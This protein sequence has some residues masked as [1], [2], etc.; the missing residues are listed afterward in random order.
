MS[1]PLTTPPQTEPSRGPWLGLGIGALLVAGII[2]FLIYSSRSSDT[3][4][5]RRA[6]V[7]QATPADPYAAQLSLTDI[8]MFEA[9]NF[10][11][12][13]SIYVEGKITNNGDKTVVGATI[14]GTFKNALDQVVQ[15]ENH[16]LMIIRAREPADDIV[17]L[18]ALPLKAGETKEFRMTFE[19]ISADWNGQYPAVAVKLVTTK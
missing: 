8:K 9:E 19:R 16:T 10:V 18:S 12:G 15:R 4:Y 17:A 13:K 14:E 3:R 2:T 6:E 11:G 7:M 5:V 1:E